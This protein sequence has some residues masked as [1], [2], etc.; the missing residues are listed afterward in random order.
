VNTIAAARGIFSVADAERLTRV[1]RHKIRGWLSGY[2]QRRDAPRAEP[3]L[4][5]QHEPID[6]ELALGF[7]DLL[8]VAFLGRLVEA[9]RQRGHAPS[10][11]AIRASAITAQ[12]ILNTEKPF[13]TRRMHTDGRSIFLEA[14][15]KTSDAGLYDLTRDNGALLGILSQ[16]FVAT[17][18]YVDDWPRTWTPSGMYPRIIVDPLRSFGRPI[19]IKSSA[20]AE[21]L[22]DAFQAE[23]G[24]AEKVARYY[25]TDAEGVS[26]AVRYTLGVDLP[27]AA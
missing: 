18:D 19:E 5:R 8:E 9:A 6:G 17:V 15:T 23:S 20:P 1:D 16:S 26:Q 24:D 12:R 21:A 10:W 27:L 13:A 14:Q 3:V 4:H 2:S 7:F 22:L 11:K 25:G